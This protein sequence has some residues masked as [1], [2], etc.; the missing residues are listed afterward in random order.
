M[1]PWSS[2]DGLS[3]GVIA[4]IAA[5]TA[6][7]LPRLPA[8]IP[9]HF[10]VRGVADGFM[11]RA[12]GAWMLPGLAL[13]MWFSLRV[14]VRAVPGAWGERMA[15]SPLDAV[16]FLCV[17]LFGAL[18]CGV[19]FAATR[20]G[21]SIGVLLG[22]VLGVTFAALGL[23]L[24]RVRR[25][26]IVG[27]RTPWTLSSDENWARTH[28]FASY[29]FVAG[30]LLSVLLSMAGIAGWPVASVLLAAIAPAVY[31]FVIRESATR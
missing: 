6:A 23:V 17:A 19:L 21:S 27:V 7:L 3:F 28:R 15:S 11:P 1:K 24:P 25:N 30:G 22:M 31:S 2:L 9:V 20:P 16:A 29:T 4:G 8:N 12:G 14:F 5:L 13:I 26:P 18:Q 10:D